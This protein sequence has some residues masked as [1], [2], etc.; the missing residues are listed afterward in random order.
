MLGATPHNS[1]NCCA[2]DICEC[3]GRGVPGEEW[4]W[5]DGGGEFGVEIV[6]GGPPWEDEATDVGRAVL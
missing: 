5:K 2:C 1:V 3:V 4:V 6:D